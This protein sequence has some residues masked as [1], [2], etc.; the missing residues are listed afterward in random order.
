MDGEKEIFDDDFIVEVLENGVT[1]W[2]KTDPHKDTRYRIKLLYSNRNFI[3]Y[4][5]APDYRMAEILD[6]FPEGLKKLLK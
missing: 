6:P 5:D 3:F 1:V 4:R 2:T